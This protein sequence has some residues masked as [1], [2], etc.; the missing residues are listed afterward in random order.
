[1]G[2]HDGQSIPKLVGHLDKLVGHWCK[3]LEGAIDCTDQL[4]LYST[5]GWDRKPQ[6]VSINYN[7]FTRAHL[8][9]EL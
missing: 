6:T 3:L 9:F 1:M 4:L 8:Y 2:D 5:Q 7:Q